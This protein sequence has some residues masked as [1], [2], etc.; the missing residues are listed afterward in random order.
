MVDATAA[1]T[2][3]TSPRAFLA[4]P[5][6]A[7]IE[8][9]TVPLGAD[10]TAYQTAEN[11]KLGDRAPY[12]YQTHDFR[13]ALVVDRIEPSA[14]QLLCAWCAKIPNAPD[15]SSPAPRPGLYS[16]GAG[17]HWDSLQNNFAHVPS[18]DDFVVQPRFDDLFVV[19]THG[20]GVWILDDIGALQAW[21]SQLA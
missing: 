19:A 9:R 6:W 7:R 2:G 12:L 8:N 16:L 11:H 15:C 18:Y 4:L 13:R 14:R 3:Q 1:R 20:R 5:E 10:G 21:N 17:A